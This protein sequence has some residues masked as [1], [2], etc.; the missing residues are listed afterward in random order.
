MSAP[1]KWVATNA[2]I[3]KEANA[4]K[5]KSKQLKPDHGNDLTGLTLHSWPWSDLPDWTTCQAERLTL[6][7]KSTVTMSPHV[8]SPLY[9][10]R[11]HR[12]W[13]GGIGSQSG[14]QKL[15]FFHFLLCRLCPPPFLFGH[16]PRM[17]FRIPAFSDSF[18]V[19]GLA[20]CQGNWRAFSERRWV[21]GRS[22]IFSSILTPCQLKQSGT[23]LE[24]TYKHSQS[25]QIKIPTRRLTRWSFSREKYP[26]MAA[27]FKKF[28][29]WHTGYISVAQT[30][31]CSL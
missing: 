25:F 13:W 5:N 23:P 11:G 20:V 3:T 7:G 31:L 18:L 2:P 29:K 9:E 15:P 22:R 10:S 24:R 6:A 8:L 30:A 17:A 19:F 21:W 26:G 28:E 16:A 1:P 4:E 27:A 12:T 14:M